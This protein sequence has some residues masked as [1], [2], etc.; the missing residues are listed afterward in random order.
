MFQNFITVC[1]GVV[2]KD[3]VMKICSLFQNF[4]TVVAE[5]LHPWNCETLR[6]VLYARTLPYILDFEPNL[7]DFGS[8]QFRQIDLPVAFKVVLVKPELISVCQRCGF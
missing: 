4:I 1:L 6:Q 2:M 8:E 5:L 3:A 7:L